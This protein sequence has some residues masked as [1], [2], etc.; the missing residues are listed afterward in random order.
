M[1]GF[2]HSEMGAPTIAVIGAAIARSSTLVETSD[3]DWDA[4][5]SV[6]LNSSFYVARAVIKKMLDSQTQGKIV[7]IGSWAASNPH[8]HIGSYSVA[9]AATRALMQN[10]ALEYAHNGILI[11]E[12]APGI[13]DA[14]LSKALFDQDPHL[15][16][17]LMESI[18]A[19]VTLTT[20]DV[21]R[22]VL[23]LL[24][25]HNRV[26]TGTVITSDGGLSITSAMNSGRPASE[27][28]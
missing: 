26:T 12:V 19:R 1:G 20:K 3:E 8:P 14:G 5:L 24:S 27:K 18:P 13:V 22:D 15:K 16:I 9:K 23:F 11:N 2:S 7:F 10:L 25:P 28:K 4:V 21:A 17:R 6:G